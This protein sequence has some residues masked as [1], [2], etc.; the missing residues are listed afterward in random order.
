[1]GLPSACRC[2]SGIQGRGRLCL[3]GFAFLTQCL[4]M[5]SMVLSHSRRVISQP[6]RLLATLTT[7]QGRNRDAGQR[8]TQGAMLSEAGGPCLAGASRCSGHK[9]LTTAHR[10]GHLTGAHLHAGRP[11]TPF[12]FSPRTQAPGLHLHLSS[13]S[14][15]PIF[16]PSSLPPAPGPVLSPDTQLF[17]SLVKCP[18][19]PNLSVMGPWPL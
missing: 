2:K 14:P 8:G 7:C 11:T 16:F 13:A 1:M 10:W 4:K 9:S 3:P 18:S 19:H 5:F 15:P 12:Q 6:G 17:I